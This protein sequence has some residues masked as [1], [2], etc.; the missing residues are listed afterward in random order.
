MSN[1]LG[2]FRRHGSV[3]FAAAL[4]LLCLLLIFASI[5]LANDP[6]HALLARLLEHLAAMGVAAV[7]AT[8]IFAFNDV[9]ESFATTISEL[10]F[11]G[12]IAKHLSTPARMAL[13]RSFL[14]E[15]LTPRPATLPLSLVERMEGIESFV[16]TM[17]HVYNYAV[18]VTVAQDAADPRL[19]RRSLRCNYRVDA[20]HL[21]DG[22][23]TFPL[24]F[25]Q[26]LSDLGHY[27]RDP[28]INF[29]LTI[30]TRTFT[31]DDL[32][33]IPATAGGRPVHRLLFSADVP[34]DGEADVAIVEDTV[35]TAPDP[36]EILYARYPTK[37]FRASLFYTPDRS[38]DAVWFRAATEVE[39]RPPGR[40]EAVSHLHGI[41]VFTNDWL[42]PGHGVVLFWFPPALGATSTEAMDTNTT[43]RTK[44]MA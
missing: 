21:K 7:V 20:R 33:V 44:E 16:Y 38:Y 5:Q 28:L 2:F 36:T 4:T 41:E 8:V 22:R 19:L 10:L 37:G 34:V 12:E 17:P 40:G 15:S 6:A 1:F 31:T 27:R 23:T 32:Q 42:L 39:W 9:Q 43:P 13:R 24:R 29:T 35:L 26:E 18:T 25:Q 30:G 3:T 11:R 14:L